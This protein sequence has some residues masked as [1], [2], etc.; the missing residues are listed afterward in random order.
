MKYLRTVKVLALEG[1]K[2]KHEFIN[3]GNAKSESHR[4]QIEYAPKE[5][6]DI[7]VT[8]LA[9][10]QIELISMGDNLD[11]RVTFVVV[12]KIDGVYVVVEAIG[13]RYNPTIV[14]TQVLRFTEEK[15]NEIK[16][17]GLVLKE[18]IYKNTQK[19]KRAITDEEKKD[20]IK[21]R[22]IVASYESN[23][24][25]S[26]TPK[27]LPHSPLFDSNISN[28]NADGN[29]LLA[30]I[31]NITNKGEM[32][33]VRNIELVADSIFKKANSS[34]SK[35]DLMTEIRNVIALSRQFCRGLIRP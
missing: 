7:V 26:H 8:M 14:S 35:A 24:S 16:N 5:I 12:K 4:G 32:T 23:D 29:N 6:M 27:T 17:D 10:D 31:S 3:H 21:N 18:V 25:F 30:Y 1:N 22:V 33:H 13:G 9:H 2:L 11:E 28:R 19:N 15:W 20:I 34:Y